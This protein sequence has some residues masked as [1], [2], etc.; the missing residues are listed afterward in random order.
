MSIDTLIRTT[1]EAMADKEKGIVAYAQL[2]QRK[3]VEMGIQI[4]GVA[5]KGSGPAKGRRNTWHRPRVK[6]TGELD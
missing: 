6:Q 5:A 2:E 3:A 4:K 1:K